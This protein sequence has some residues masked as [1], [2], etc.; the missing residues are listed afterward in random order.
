MKYKVGNKVKIKTWED[1]EKEF[2]LRNKNEIKNIR[3]KEI[4][5]IRS[6][7]DELNRRFPDRLLEISHVQKTYYCMKE[8]GWWW[9]DNMIEC[10]VEDYKEFIPIKN[11]W[12][13]LDL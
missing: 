12:E 11:R 9:L 13:L 6:Q 7:D 1:M 4:S 8:M 3:N 5:F 2:G 10:L